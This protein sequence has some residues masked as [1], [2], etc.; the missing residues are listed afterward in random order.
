MDN[1]RHIVSI[2]LAVT[3]AFAVMLLAWAVWQERYDRIL[4][5]LVVTNFA[6][7]IGLPF[8]AITSFIVVTLFRQTEGAV[9]FEAFGV[10]L[11]GSAG[12]TI[13]WVICFL[14]I[15]AAIALLWR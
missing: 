7:I 3:S 4:T 1:I 6:A 11:K 15:A 14:S 12:Q 9:E 8:A 2:I 5:E 13:L 10:K